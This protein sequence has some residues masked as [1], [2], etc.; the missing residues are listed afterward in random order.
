[1]CASYLAL[2]KTHSVCSPWAQS[3]LLCSEVRTPFAA[4]TASAGGHSGEQTI[5]EHS[6][7]QA[8]SEEA[9]EEGD[10]EADAE[11]NWEADAEGGR[12][13]DTSAAETKSALAGAQ[14]AQQQAVQAQQQA[15]TEQRQS[16]VQMRQDLQQQSGQPQPN[17]C[18]AY[19]VPLKTHFL[20]FASFSVC[21]MLNSSRCVSTTNS[22]H[23]T[24]TANKSGIASPGSADHHATN[25]ELKCKFY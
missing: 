24:T 10:K 3:Q 14:E 11:G 25:S 15:L 18:E 23:H 20:L 12:E 6:L 7:G 1:M 16:L 17:P 13:A 8:L 2:L 22:M 19:T 5:Q 4:A 21:C 9:D